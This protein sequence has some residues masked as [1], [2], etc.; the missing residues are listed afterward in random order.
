MKTFNSSFMDYSFTAKTES[1]LDQIAYKGR[2]WNN[3]IEEFY[4]I[5]SQLSENVP[6]E[7]YQ[8]EKNLG[9]FEGKKMIARIAKFGP[10]IQIGEKDDID[11]G[12]PRYFNISYDQLIR[13]ISINEAIEIINK[14]D[15]NNSLPSFE[16]QRW[17]YRT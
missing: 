11:A 17:K 15:E 4:S 14:K 1:Q 5:F 12:F 10:V 3:M 8:L 7:R 9:E 6:E 16:H 2:N 13:H